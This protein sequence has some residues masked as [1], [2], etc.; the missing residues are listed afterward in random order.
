MVD[1]RQHS[2][3]KK[4]RIQCSKECAE[5]LR[6]WGKESWLRKREDK[7]LAKGKGEMETYWILPKRAGTARSGAMSMSSGDSADFDESENNDAVE[8]MTNQF[9]L[10][11]RGESTTPVTPQID[12]IADFNYDIL[13]KS[14]KAIVSKRNITPKKPVSRRLGRS[15]SNLW[16]S[17]RE[18][19]PNSC[20][21]EVAE[22]IELPDDGDQ[23]IDEWEN[24]VV[25]IPQKVKDQ[26]REYCRKIASMYQ[27]SN[28]FHNFEHASHVTQSSSKLLSRIVSIRNSDTFGI[29]ADPLT[30]FAVIFSSMIHG[31]SA[32]Y[33]D[34]LCGMN[35]QQ[36]SFF[37]F[38]F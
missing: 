16:N 35:P 12:L 13:L 5:Q 37:L 10:S 21:D 23:P 17:D 26:L 7:V 29:A 24:A 8:Y 14:L 25:E 19:L 15:L 34:V 11:A 6:K 4:G 18:I 9:D 27:S 3:G 38:A 20:L 31:T 32:K 33:Y 28:P 1:S 22:V 30:H 36:N 2:T